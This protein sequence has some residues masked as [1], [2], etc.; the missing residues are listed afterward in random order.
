MVSSVL[1]ELVGDA[2]EAPFSAKS[3]EEGVNCISG[4]DC[5]PG[6]CE[7]DIAGMKVESH[8]MIPR[9]VW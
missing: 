7:V 3:G 8:V 4:I 9:R 5:A 2:G 6:V 1:V